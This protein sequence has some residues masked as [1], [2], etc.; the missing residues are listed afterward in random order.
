MP[1]RT[2]DDIWQIIDSAEKDPAFA[3]A[4]AKILAVDSTHPLLT[5]LPATIERGLPGDP[6]WKSGYYRMMLGRYLIAARLGAGQVVLDSCSGLGWGTLLLSATAARA[7]VFDRREDAL[8]FAREVW[9]PP[10]LVE[11]RR[12]DALVD[13][14]DLHGR[15]DLV[16]AME[17]VEHFVKPDGV[18][19][20]RLLG[21]YLKPGGRIVGTTHLGE[22][23]AEAD[24]FN[25]DNPYHLYMWTRGE[26]EE[27][28]GEEFTDVT[29]V[30]NWM[31]HAVKR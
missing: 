19:Y 18:G 9:S 20:L 24:T 29:V 5:A 31:F 28:L 8:H 16:T 27:T 11:F 21:Q 13:Q 2:W 10:P 7:V 25:R 17:T 4:I 26:I 15:F 22:T 14:P 3:P 6:Q 23:R 1:P 30:R 12:F